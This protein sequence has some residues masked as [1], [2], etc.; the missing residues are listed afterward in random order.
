M[1]EPPKGDVLSQELQR[2][3]SVRRTAK[4]LY[5]QRSR[6]N[7]ELERLISHLYLL[8]AIPRQTPE[9]PQPESDILIEAAQR[10]NDPVFSDLLIQLIRERKK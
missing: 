5:D 9:F 3:R 6:I 7:E 2:E 10:L 8:V 1:N 4:L